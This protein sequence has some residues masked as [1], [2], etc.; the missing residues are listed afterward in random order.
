MSPSSIRRRLIPGSLT[1]QMLLAV[2]A[3]LLLVQGLGA[4]LIYRAERDRLEAEA[5]NAVA[6]RLMAQARGSE[7][8]ARER[9]R[10]TARDVF[11]N[12]PHR[13]SVE[14]SARTP[15]RAG[16]RRDASAEEK[17][18]EILSSQDFPTAEVVV[19]RR[20]VSADT[21]ARQALARREQRLGLPEG[22]AERT[23]RA[24]L[25]VAGVRPAG[26]TAWMVARV[27]APPSM[28]A[29]LVPLLLQTL[30][31]YLVLVGVVAWILRRI[32]R[33]LAALTRQVEHFAATQDP[34]AQVEP[35]GPQDVRRLIEALNAME[36]R[37]AALLDEK[38]VM[39][40]AIGHDLKTPLTALRVRIESVEDEAE[41]GRMARTIEDIVHTLDDILSLARVGRPSDPRERT[42]LS[43]LVASIVEE[44]EDMGEPVELEDTQRTV[45]ELRPTWL[46]R[47]LRNLLDNAVRYGTRARVSMANEGNAAVIRVDDDGPGIP[48]ASIEAMMNPFT[49]GDPS[50]NSATGG[51][52]LGLALARAIAEQHGGTLSLTNR[53]APDG[54]VEGLSARI[55]LP[56]T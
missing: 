51:A 7:R 10:Q 20:K 18:H 50:R 26:S 21:F 14:P 44:Y 9:W 27:R 25:M 52:G 29:M 53:R 31:L 33:P 6:F 19:F 5:M 41:R 30:A 12:R 36:A 38:D 39:L 22:S 54:R 46:R 34:S 15:Q 11:A 3:A 32:T 2:A 23:W 55:I 4:M 43:A 16:E 13:F 24:D 35:T 28:N 40:G 49:R 47:A 1:G 17:L 37:I 56:L 8:I 48:E 42:E 45:L